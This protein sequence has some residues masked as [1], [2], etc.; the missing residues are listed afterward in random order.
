MALKVGELFASFDLD[1]SGMTGTIRTIETQL[2]GIGADMIRAGSTLSSMVTDPLKGIGKSILSAGMD[3]TSQMSRVEA[4]SG[5][6]AAEMEKLNAEALKMGSTTQFTATEAGQALEYMAMAGW[7]TS[8]M[9]NGLEP[10]MNL[11]AASGE[12][13]ADVSDIVTDAMTAFGLEAKK[14]NIARFSD[15]LAQAASNSN[16]NVGLM[17]ETFKYV[18]PVAG[19]LGYNIEDAAIAIGLMANAG[20][21]GSQS[22][23]ALRCPPRSWSCPAAPREHSSRDA[24]RA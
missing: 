12:N 7:K 19:A 3:F 13:L 24:S 9:I 16:T 18:A 1:A 6:S 5:A 11:A 8:A 14:E 15:V 21:K 23:T 20:I 17:G 22:G 10:I 4:I 2:E